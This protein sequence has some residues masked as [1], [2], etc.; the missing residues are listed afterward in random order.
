MFTFKPKK[1]F[2]KLNKMDRKQAYTIGAIAVVSVVA[3]ILLISAASQ[4]GD[5]S[6]P[7][8]STHGYDLAQMPFATDEAE[9]Y[10]L[11]NAYPDMKEG[12]SLLYTPQEKEERQ[13]EDAALEGEEGE[14][15]EFDENSSGSSSSDDGGYS[16]G[17]SSRGY[18]GYG[19][20]SG[21]GGSKTEIGQLGSANMAHS[22]GSGI[23][24]QWGPSGDFR[25]FRKD[26]KGREKPVQL[27]N[28]DARRSLSQFRSGSVAAARINENKLTNARRAAMGGNI[29][30]SDAFGKDGSVDLSK[31][32]NGGL[33]LDTSAPASTTDLSN[34][35]K[36][37][38]DAAKKAENEKKKE[39]DKKEWWEEML[40]NLAKSA[41]NSLVNSVMGAFGDTI[42]GTIQG[43][44]ASRMA[45][46]AEGQRLAGVDYTSLSDADKAY[47]QKNFSSVLGADKVSG[48][49][50]EQ[51]RTAYNEMQGDKTLAKVM[52]G[53]P[54]ARYEGGVARANAFS[55]G[56]AQSAANRYAHESNQ[57]TNNNGNGNTT[58]YEVNGTKITCTNGQVLNSDQTGCADPS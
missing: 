6:M 18:G 53:A 31:L 35:D 57:R 17:S 8:M 41:A 2:E 46:K 13:E 27:R 32:Q 51:W 33:T 16:S 12:G 42:S 48:W 22:G 50:D 36:K 1:V 7:G 29:D 14:N 11:A 45:R 19:G 58:T 15:T 43:N 24:S 56:A 37:V 44:Q 9:K 54:A 26:D 23:N 39:E 25:Q 52:S 30:G 47:F 3:L 5:D 21:R 10:L 55:A 28:S 40:I 20:G 38:A 49:S 4:P 34:L